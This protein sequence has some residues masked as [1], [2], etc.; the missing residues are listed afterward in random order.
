MAALIA[1]DIHPVSNLR[2]LNALRQD[3]GADDLGVNGWVS[4]WITDGFEALEQ[5]VVRHGNASPSA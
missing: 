4:R 1:C 3:F 5:H 2:V